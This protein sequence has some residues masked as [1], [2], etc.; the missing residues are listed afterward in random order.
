MKDKKQTELCSLQ[1]VAVQVEPTNH[2]E[3]EVREYGNASFWCVNV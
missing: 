3:S 2:S 1:L